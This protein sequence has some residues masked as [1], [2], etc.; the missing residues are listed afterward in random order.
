MQNSEETELFADDWGELFDEERREFAASH[1][2]TQRK[3]R[4]PA[5]SF[6]GSVLRERMLQVEAEQQ[7]NARPAH[8]LARAAF[9]RNVSERRSEQVDIGASGADVS[10][11]RDRLLVQFG[12]PG[13]FEFIGHG[14]Q[15]AI[16][17]AMTHFMTAHQISP[18]TPHT[19]DAAW[20]DPLVD[21]QL[22]GSL[23]NMS[24]KALADLV[25]ESNP[26]KRTLSIASAILET[27]FYLWGLLLC[28][29][30]R[31]VISGRSTANTSADVWRPILFLFKLRY[32]ETPTKVRVA[33]P[34]DW[35]NALNTAGAG[36]N[37]GNAAPA[38]AHQAS[39]HAK[40]LQTEFSMGFLL[41]NATSG[42]FTWVTGQVPTCLTAM[43][44][45]TG[46]TTF[47]VLMEVI[48]SIPELR[49]AGNE[50]KVRVRHT[51]CDGYSA[52]VKAERLIS[53]HLAEFDFVNTFCDVHKLYS[54]TKVAM[55]AIESDVTGMLNV[56]LS[57]A[58]DLNAVSKL[59]QMF[60]QILSRKLAITF[61]CPPEGRVEKFRLELF[62]A[63]L[64]LQGVTPA[65][66]KQHMKRRYIIGYFLNGPL[67]DHNT[68][69]HYCQ[70]GCC[71]SPETTLTF[72][73]TFLAWA[74]CPTKVPRF[75]RSAHN[76]LED[77][78]LLYVG[79]VAATPGQGQSDQPQA[80]AV[81][82]DNRDNQWQQLYD[83]V[84]GRPAIAHGPEPE[85]N[86]DQQEEAAEQ[87]MP[88][89]VMQFDLQRDEE[90]G[91]QLEPDQPKLLDTG[92]VDWATFNR[93]KKA[94]ARVW[95]QS[96][97][98]ARLVLV[99]EVVAILMSLMHTFLL[100]SGTSWEKKQQHKAARGLQ[101]SYPV[102]EAANGQDLQKAMQRLN[103]LL[104]MLP[105]GLLPERFIPSLRA[106]RFSMISGALCSLHSYLRLPRQ[107][108]R[109][110][111]FRLLQSGTLS[112]LLQTPACMRDSVAN[113][114]L[115]EYV[116]WQNA[117]G[118]HFTLF[119][120]NTQVFVRKGNSF[121]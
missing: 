83:E 16:F 22:N 40:V 27:G 63:F 7:A 93:Q 120:Q 89:H 118:L 86:A 41:H 94:K 73:S 61:E 1:T 87:N 64:P 48:D 121:G 45:T 59:Q 52:N 75:A 106:L 111:V 25:R 17:Q 30:C 115:R 77:L 10:A 109:F 104:N 100:Y 113:L 37:A 4:R 69:H 35:R 95:V 29:V 117:D 12:R 11:E 51:C 78:I 80:K 65:R 32:D 8:E 103:D 66:K 49:R 36:A 112:D 6:G 79:G 101:R 110:A 92:E 50:F 105:A 74:L 108:C 5:G 114:L 14:V 62:D 98:Y 43:Q 19:E 72:M 107:G 55:T 42:K 102:M 38:D 71:T 31:L 26:G 18:T 44:N 34:Q 60:G 97:P 116:P 70:Y 91:E 96:Q 33:D 57:M 3:S 82:P 56:A 13:D 46:E 58:G 119:A 54:C 15:K 90:G 84:E 9:L 88:Q 67:F 85:P 21:R 39:L 47:K 99:K 28:F 68:V 53:Q 23:R 20:Y 76:L 24:F 81:A 2:Q